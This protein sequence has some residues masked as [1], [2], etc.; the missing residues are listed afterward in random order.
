MNI[1]YAALK[2]D[3]KVRLITGKPGVGKTYFGCRLAGFELLKSNRKLSPHQKVLFLTFA[4]NAVARIREV[5]LQQVF[6]ATH[7]SET[8]KESKITEFHNR[9]NAN[10]FAGFFW[11]LVGSYGRYLPGNV[12]ALLTPSCQAHPTMRL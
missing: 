12:S 2:S 1:R 6:N 8:A 11:W 4:R 9:V 7:L 10:T 5:Y 3:A